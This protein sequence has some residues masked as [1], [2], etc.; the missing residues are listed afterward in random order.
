MP[1][2]LW[3]SCQMAELSS[4]GRDG[5]AK[6]IDSLAKENFADHWPGDF[7]PGK[8]HKLW[9]GKSGKQTGIWACLGLED[10]LQ[11]GD[12]KADNAHLWQIWVAEWFVW[13]ICLF[14]CFVLFFTCSI[15]LYF[16]KIKYAAAI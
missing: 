14:V 7:C 11:A 13:R 1:I 16:L 9:E 10:V 6:N 15:L 2:C 3:F 12:S 5:K 8:W 4:C